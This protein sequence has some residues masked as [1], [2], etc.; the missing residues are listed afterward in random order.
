MDATPGRNAHS[1][2]AGSRFG[3]LVTPRPQ[4]KAVSS[5]TTAPSTSGYGGLF[6]VPSMA[7]S[8]FKP[9][10]PLNSS[11]NTE[12]IIRP[13]SV[14]ESVASS[15]HTQPEKTGFV[16]GFLRTV[17]GGS[18]GSKV[19]EIA[20]GRS[21]RRVTEIYDPEKEALKVR[22]ARSRGSARFD[23]L[24]RCSPTYV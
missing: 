10:W 22:S 23:G 11:Q 17:S 5:A 19:L 14:A 6:K 1:S 12:E 13:P 4:L 2:F 3:A 15:S 18:H 20:T 16:T 9:L 21:S 8:A 7:R 24:S